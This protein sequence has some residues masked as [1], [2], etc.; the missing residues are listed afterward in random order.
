MTARAAHPGKVGRSEFDKPA[1]GC[2]PDERKADLLRRTLFDGRFATELLGQGKLPEGKDQVNNQDRDGGPE[3]G[4]C[5][6][7]RYIALTE[8]V[9][10]SE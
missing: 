7:L 2:P 3:D 1:T 5:H 8:L 4:S 9:L 10:T 6:G